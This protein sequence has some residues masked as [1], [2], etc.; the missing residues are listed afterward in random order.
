LAILNRLRG[1][2]WSRIIWSGVSLVG[3]GALLL[4]ANRAHDAWEPFAALHMPQNASYNDWVVHIT[5]ATLYDFAPTIVQFRGLM[6]FGC[7]VVLAMAI[8]VI[9]D[10]ARLIRQRRAHGAAPLLAHPQ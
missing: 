6:I 3:A 7:L 2:Q 4:L 8:I 5:S 9:I 10:A 1:W